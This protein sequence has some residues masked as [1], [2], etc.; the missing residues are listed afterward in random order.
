MKR[1]K[2]IQ[3]HEEEAASYRRTAAEAPGTPGARQCLAAARDHAD[4]AEAARLNDYPE[5]LED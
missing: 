5:N 4:L 3:Y 1:S 2:A